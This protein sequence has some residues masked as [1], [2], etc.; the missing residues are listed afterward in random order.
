MLRFTGRRKRYVPTGSMVDLYGF[1]WEYGN[2]TELATDTNA[3]QSSRMSV[4]NTLE[5]IGVQSALTR[6]TQC[7]SRVELL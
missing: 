3:Y 2:T 5:A 4:A 7:A 1:Q 6:M